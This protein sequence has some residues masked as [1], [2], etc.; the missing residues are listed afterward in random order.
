MDRRHFLGTGSVSAV[1]LAPLAAGMAAAALPA[2]AATS[3]PSKES[4]AMSNAQ[5]A[6]LNLLSR[7]NTVL[8]LTDP[9]HAVPVTIA[10][11]S[12]VDA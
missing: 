11:F 12:W 5:N 9:D 8:L 2:S 7:E 10:P 4:N 3:T 6:Y 1:A